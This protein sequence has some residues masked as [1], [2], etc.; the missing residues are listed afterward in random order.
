MLEITASS[1][2]GVYTAITKDSYIVVNG[3]V[4]SPY[5][6][7]ISAG[8]FNFSEQTFKKYSVQNEVSQQ[9]ATRKAQARLL[10]GGA[11]TGPE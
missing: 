10:R 1:K 5:S 6:E 11:E 7:I 8:K 9:Y 2:P 3:I 4:A